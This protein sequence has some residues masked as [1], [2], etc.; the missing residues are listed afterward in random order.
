MKYY[1]KPIVII[2]FLFSYPLFADDE[3]KDNMKV[4]ESNIS[5]NS[6]NEI[7]KTAQ[8]FI[9]SLDKQQSKN[10]I[11]K[12][13]DESRTTGFCYVLRR[14][15][16][17]AGLLFAELHGKQIIKFNMLLASLLN[18]NGY[19]KVNG[20]INRQHILRE[21]EE[22]QKKYPS[23]YKLNGPNKEDLRTGSDSNW[24]PPLGRTNLTYYIA[25]YGDINSNNWGVRIEGHHLTINYTFI[26][27]K[28]N[29]INVDTYPLF[30]GVSPMIVPSAPNLTSE[31][32]PF[33]N[34][35]QGQAVL[36]HSV[37]LARFFIN[38]LSDEQKRKSNIDKLAPAILYG[39]TD[40]ELTDKPLEE[41]K[42]F[43]TTDILSQ[44]QLKHLNKFIKEYTDISNKNINNVK[45]KPDNMKISWS[46]DLDSDY[47]NFYIRLE[48]DDILLELS[49]SD[50]YGVLIPDM[51]AIHVHSALRHKKNDWGVSLL[52]HI[53]NHQH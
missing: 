43:I 53:K 27:D 19:K 17:S 42:Q 26:K 4:I 13:D 18:S 45:I 40:K 51:Q 33:W 24:Q 38:T 37:K 47:Q 1:F 14:C 31:N 36:W 12:F 39:S 6:Y 30:L 3:N 9:D 15:N 8:D 21:M 50:S 46:G 7:V 2:L 16:D 29:N 22:I 10:L 52:N 11:Q 34:A 44:R 23:L 48:H 32:I 28:N 5:Q 49:Q 25:I 35:M 20:I 41:I